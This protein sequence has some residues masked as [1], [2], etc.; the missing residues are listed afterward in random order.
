MTRVQSIFNQYRWVGIIAGI[1]LGVWLFVGLVWWG[2]VWAISH[3]G[4]EEKL[5]HELT[6]QWLKQPTW[7]CQL[8]HWQGFADAHGLRLQIRQAQI[9]DAQGQVLIKVKR[10]SVATSLWPLLQRKPI[11]LRHIQLDGL[12][13]QANPLVQKAFVTFLSG[14][15]PPNPIAWWVDPLLVA[16]NVHVSVSNSQWSGLE[17]FIPE[18]VWKP[19]GLSFTPHVVLAPYQFNVYLRDQQLT[20]GHNEL[21]LELRH[22]MQPWQPIAVRARVFPKTSATATYQVDPIAIA[23][24]VPWAKVSAW[25]PRLSP[26]Q[27]QLLQGSRWAGTI[28]ATAEG[29]KHWPKHGPHTTSFNGSGAVTLQGLHWWQVNHSQPLLVVPK[30]TIQWKSASLASASVQLAPTSLWW[31]GQQATIAVTPQKPMVSGPVVHQVAWNSENIELASVWRQIQD[32]L[33]PTV[34]PRQSLALAEGQASAH[35]TLTGNGS[36]P[37]EQWRFA[38]DVQGQLK[39]LVWQGPQAKMP[40]KSAQFHGQWG[41]TGAQWQFDLTDLLSGRAKATGAWQLTKPMTVQDWIVPAKSVIM[42]APFKATVGWDHLSVSQMMAAVPMAQQL[43][44]QQRISPVSQGFTSGSLNIVGTVAK[45]L[46]TG[47]VTVSPSQW[48]TPQGVLALQSMALGI[49]PSGLAF[50]AQQPLQAEW[51]GIPIRLSGDWKTGQPFPTGQMAWGPVSWRQLAQAT[52]QGVLPETRVEGLAWGSVNQTRQGQWQGQAAWSDSRWLDSRVGQAQ[53]QAG[54]MTFSLPS[55]G[56]LTWRMSPVKAQWLPVNSVAE[57]K[58]TRLVPDGPAQLHIQGEG[59]LLR[60]ALMMGDLEGPLGAVR[61]QAVLTPPLVQ[62]ASEKTVN[63]PEVASIVLDQTHHVTLE[64]QAQGPWWQPSQVEVTRFEWQ[65]PVGRI[66]ATGHVQHPME[67]T[68]QWAKATLLTPEPLA[69]GRLMTE[70]ILPWLP[71]AQREQLLSRRA[72]QK[73]SSGQ[74]SLALGFEGNGKETGLLTGRVN[75]EHLR[76]PWADISDVTGYIDYGG[77]DG[78]VVLESIGLPGAQLGVKAHIVDDLLYPIR[79][80]QVDVVGSQFSVPAWDQWVGQTL[81]KRLGEGLIQPLLAT[82]QPPQRVTMPKAPTMDQPSLNIPLPSKPPPPVP[83]VFENATLSLDEVVYDTILIT[84]MTGQLSL[85]ES[86]FFDLQQARG[87]VADGTVEASVSM[88]PLKN[89]FTR[90]D[91]DAHRVSGNALMT[92][93]LNAPNQ[94]FGSVDGRIRFTTEGATPD[95]Q[96]N[97]T[98]G[99]VSFS[100]HNGRVPAIAKIESLLTAANVLRGGVLGLNLNNMVR[101]FTPFRTDYFANLSGS[102]SL[103]SGEAHTDDMLSD[104]ED[105]DLLAEGTMRLKDGY[106]DLTVYGDMNQVVRG[107]LGSVGKWSLLNVVKWIPGVGFFPGQSNRKRLGGILA[108]VPGV[109][110]VPFLGGPLGERQRFEVRIKGLLDDPNAFQGFSWTR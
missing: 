25:W 5:A 45:P 75:V 56:D 37:L 30:A 99:L 88:D 102:L 22:P 13:I 79:L 110:F 90:V 24:W 48:Q 35:V 105:L 17:W 87:T 32:L 58:S 103:L 7:Q 92:A 47:T 104:G 96:L 27:R 41:P 50:N 98:N 26:Q 80:D 71:T 51:Q 68:K 31:L 3:S 101:L 2:L 16:D 70:G 39:Q 63:T 83:V 4:W 33:G 95:D 100:I 74:L 46:T 61:L 15:P 43:L 29:P 23:A 52:G 21:L 106:S 20:L 9:T 28:A 10:L 97:A 57:A 76:W 84:Q 11:Q 1:G 107:R 49:T 85:F 6:H 108:Y 91:L 109:G 55:Q 77:V 78:R 73:P 86:G 64:A 82:W 18:P 8:G 59:R 53:W 93:L 42:Q 81:G 60:Q 62:A 14:P 67:A 72:F 65:S 54:Q 38:G 66:L 94:L 89:N 34:L 69:L 36:Q 40:I 44:N 19:L 12:M